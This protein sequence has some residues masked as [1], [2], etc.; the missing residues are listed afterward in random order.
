[1]GAGGQGGPR[2]YAAAGTGFHLS[3]PPADHFITPPTPHVFS[4]LYSLSHGSDT[5]FINRTEGRIIPSHTHV[6][7]NINVG[8]V[9]LRLMNISVTK[10]ST[11]GQVVLPVDIR[12][13]MNIHPHDKL[14]LVAQDE[15]LI[16]KKIDSRSFRELM[17]PLWNKT[18]QLGLDED[19]IDELITEA[20][21]S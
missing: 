20:R 19:D 3:G 1:M 4:L 8:Y 13:Q 16:V 7:K 6:G 10:V 14:L 18:R 15:T 11:K 5:H 12:H 17:E 9:L 2:V 21:S